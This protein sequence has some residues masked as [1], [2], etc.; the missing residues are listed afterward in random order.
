[1][2]DIQ[3]PKVDHCRP[4][5]LSLKNLPMLQHKPELYKGLTYPWGRANSPAPDQPE[6][7]G[8]KDYSF[9]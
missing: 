3:P 5:H 2:L 9:E 8:P 1:M 7:S 4:V 6:Q